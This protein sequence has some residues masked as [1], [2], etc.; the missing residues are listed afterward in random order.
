MRLWRVQNEFDMITRIPYW[1]PPGNDWQHAQ[2]YHLWIRQGELLVQAHEMV[3]GSSGINSFTSWGAGASSSPLVHKLGGPRGY[4]A[5]LRKA[6]TTSRIGTGQIFPVNPVASPSADPDQSV[7]DFPN[8]SR[9]RLQVV[10]AGLGLGLALWC[11]I[12]AVCVCPALVVAAALAATSSDSAENDR[13]AAQAG[14]FV[15]FLVLG[16]AAAAL[17]YGPWVL[18]YRQTTGFWLPT[19]LPSQTMLKTAPFVAQALGRS[20]VFY[21]WRLLRLCP[22]YVLALLLPLKSAWNGLLLFFL[23][24]LH[25]GFVRRHV[26][27]AAAGWGFI[28]CMT[29]IGVIFGGGFQMRFILPATPPLALLAAEAATSPRAWRS[30]RWFRAFV[31]P[32]LTSRPVPSFALFLTAIAAA[33]LAVGAMHTLFYGVLF[34]PLHAE[35]GGVG[36]EP[37]DVWSMVALAFRSDLPYPPPEELRRTF[38][39][40]AHYGVEL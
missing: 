34:A 22:V 7:S 29:I 16:T 13:M 10:V 36:P 27:L 23:S 25:E 14:A 2:T 5:A 18:W 33:S 30:R 9:I 39:V 38:S 28:A 35:L 12:T 3:L 19:A 17:T 20:V 6:L 24:S 31:R 11:K 15:E 26:F 1:F 40:L 8:R 32:S 4:V 37:A 21:V